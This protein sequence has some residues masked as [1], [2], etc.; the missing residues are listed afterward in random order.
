MAAWRWGSRCVMAGVDRVI[1]GTSGSPGSLRALRCAEV[2]AR[3]HH[4]VLIPVVA[5]LPPEGDRAAARYCPSGELRRVWQ[6]MACQRL[7]DALIAV[8]G[9][10][11]DDP[12]VEPHVERGE[13][14]W[15]LVS[16]AC[17]PD[18]LL[19]VGAGRRGALART[20]FSRVSRYCA[21]HAQCPVL[22]I[23]RLH[24]L[25]R[26]DMACMHGR[27]GTGTDPGSGPSGSGQHSRRRVTLRPGHS[28]W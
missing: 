21:A 11:P 26:S 25:R 7:R 6:D 17:R 14:G 10:V 28:C 9:E 1:A 5:W 12:M 3:A 18:D 13:A 19:V 2:V 27:F 16:L 15:V 8:W 4:A 24:S 22:T 23:P 20:V